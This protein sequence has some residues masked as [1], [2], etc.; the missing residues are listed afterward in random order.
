MGD[1]YRT[2]GLPIF[3]EDMITAAIASRQLE[4]SS[5]LNREGGRDVIQ[6]GIVCVE[7]VRT[8]N[9]DTRQ[10]KGITSFL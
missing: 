4:E 9:C 7:A 8:F 6:F 5:T 3:S 2:L 1:R 10:M